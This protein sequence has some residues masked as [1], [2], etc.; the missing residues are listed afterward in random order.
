MVEM[1][2]GA[3]TIENSME[4]PYKTKNSWTFLEV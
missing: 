2:T 1:E 3:V 4:V